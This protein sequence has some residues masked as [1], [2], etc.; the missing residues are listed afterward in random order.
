MLVA[1]VLVV[2][3]PFTLPF[4]ILACSVLQPLLKYAGV[5][6]V[7]G[8]EV[9]DM[10]MIIVGFV[11]FMQTL[12][13]IPLGLVVVF[14]SAGPEDIL[15]NVV[16]VQIFANLDDEVVRA[17]ANP[18]KFK[19]EALETYC[20]KA[21]EEE[22]E[23]NEELEEWKGTIEARGMPV[24][25]KGL[26]ASIFVALAAYVAY[27]SIPDFEA[28]VHVRARHHAARAAALR[29]D[30][31]GADLHLGRARQR[32]PGADRREAS[33]PDH[34]HRVRALR[35][36]ARRAARAARLRPVP[37]QRA[38]AVLR[39]QRVRAARR[40]A[41]RRAADDRAL[42]ARDHHHH[43]GRLRDRRVYLLCRRA[44]LRDA[45]R[46]VRRRLLRPQ[47]AEDR[48]PRDV[49]R[50]GPPGDEAEA[51]RGRPAPGSPD[52]AR[53]RPQNALRRARRGL[54]RARLAMTTVA[55]PHVGMRSAGVRPSLI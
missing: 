5:T 47:R 8:L 44:R 10:F 1:I 54:P 35:V 37:E 49:L 39:H 2:V 30:Q 23:V 29:H 43:R 53:R 7:C 21:K 6:K 9:D 22:E 13:L 20:E 42:P 41:D 12:V 45:R 18:G 27:A 48:G 17:F 31:H 11:D 14:S 25:A 55:R 38:Q 36:P 34:V 4:L 40:R 52:T 51:D 33:Q 46:R 3:L 28:N 24:A 32:V 15:V 19:Y 26:L 50:E 16:A